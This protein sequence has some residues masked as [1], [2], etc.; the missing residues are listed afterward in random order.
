MVK[1]VV[2][3]EMNDD[4]KLCEKFPKLACY[5]NCFVQCQSG[6]FPPAML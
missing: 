5:N 4:I 6:D 3:Q 2:K 1:K